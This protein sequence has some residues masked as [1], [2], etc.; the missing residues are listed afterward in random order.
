M[1]KSNSKYHVI[2]LIFTHPFLARY[3]KRANARCNEIFYLLF[4]FFC[5]VKL[6]C[7]CPIWWLA[8]FCQGRIFYICPIHMH[9]QISLM[10]FILL[11]ANAP[12]CGDSS[13]IHCS[14]PLLTVN[15][16]QNYIFFGVKICVK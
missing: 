16:L 4:F 5:M 14:K 3:T 10:C 13:C 8:N 9:T 1:S 12:G 6:S 15:Y 2:V 11:K 7:S